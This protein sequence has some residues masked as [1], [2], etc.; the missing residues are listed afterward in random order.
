MITVV[1]DGG[2]VKGQ[3]TSGILGITYVNIKN[4]A[5]V[6]AY[7][8]VRRLRSN[9]QGQKMQLTC[10]CSSRDHMTAKELEKAPG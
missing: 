1:Q 8:S 9:S 10:N 5:V 6:L 3:N 7:T 4:H 2:D